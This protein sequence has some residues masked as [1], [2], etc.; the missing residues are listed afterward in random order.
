M[1]GRGKGAPNAP[2]AERPHGPEPRAVHAV[3]VPQRSRHP[4]PDLFPFLVDE[5]FPHDRQACGLRQAARG[6]RT[7]CRGRLGGVARRGTPATGTTPNP[8]TWSGIVAAGGSPPGAT[9]AHAFAV[10]ADRHGGND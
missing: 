4:Q 1:R 7:P 3:D 8:T 6:T 9:A 5:G 10:C 2:R